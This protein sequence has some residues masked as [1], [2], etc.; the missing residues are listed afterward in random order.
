MT[1]VI[2]ITFQARYRTSSWKNFRR[3]RGPIPRRPPP[4]S[5]PLYPNQS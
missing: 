3:F 1:R 5:A 2:T 4:G